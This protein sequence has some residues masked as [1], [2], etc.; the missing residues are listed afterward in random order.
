VGEGEESKKASWAGPQGGKRER[1]KEKEGV[2]QAQ[3]EKVGEKE[4]HS[5][6]FEFKF[7]I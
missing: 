3:I 6:A 1:E 2:C 4:L 7:K 5:N